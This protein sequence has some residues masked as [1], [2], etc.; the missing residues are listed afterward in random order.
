MFIDVTLEYFRM[1]V[2]RTFTFTAGLNTIRG[3]NEGGKSTI[4]HAILYAL[5]GAKALPLPV[6]DMVTWGEKS[7]KLKVTFRIMKA[8]R[9]FSFVRSEKGAEVRVDG[10]TLVTGQKEVTAYAAQLLGADMGMALKL[11]FASQK[12][13]SNA[14]DGGAASMSAY[15]EELS[16]MSLFDELLDAAGDY[17]TTG[18]TSTLDVGIEDLERKVVVAVPEP[19]LTL[20]KG[21]VTQKEQG[22]AILELHYKDAEQ[23]HM[24]AIQANARQEAL[25]REAAAAHK[26]ANDADKVYSDA[27]RAESDALVNTL[28]TVDEDRA[29][30]I[31]SLLAQ[32]DMHAKVVKIY[33]EFKKL[34]PRTEDEWDESLESMMEELRRCKSDRDRLNKEISE[35]NYDI[36]E[37]KSRLITETACGL[38]GK[39]LSDVPEVQRKNREIGDNIQKLSDLLP[40]LVA[41]RDSVVNTIAALEDIAAVNAAY[42]TFYTKYS[43]FVE[44]DD[45]VIPIHLDWRGN[46][47]EAVQDDGKLRDELA[48]IDA[49]RKKRDDA[50]ARLPILKEATARAE[51]AFSEAEAKAQELQSKLP[52]GED[53]RD[54][55]VD[56]R[57]RL[58]NL[59]NQ[60]AIARD[61]LTSAKVRVMHA[62]DSYR[63]AVAENEANKAMLE[64]L[65]E[66]RRVQVYNNN[67]VKKI[68]SARPIVAAKLWSV[69]L[70]SV[71]NMF[72]SMRGEQSIVTRDADTFLVN[73][74]SFKGVSGS[75]QDILGLAMRV[76]LVRTFIPD[77]TTLILDEPMAA[78]DDGRSASLLAFVQSCG[79]DQVILVTHEDI[80]DSMSANLITV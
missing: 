9:I 63:R 14:L 42:E 26:S 58:T 5:Y 47:P 15:I 27:V 50:N 51:K 53:V 55:L 74:K 71:S 62:E 57:S 45:S 61:E 18:P 32:Q 29:S 49:E 2:Q 11:M 69:V 30:T 28:I 33:D 60:L 73:G 6:D 19:D 3:K 75:A 52:K 10:G 35:T 37:W 24:N 77:T 46:P 38:C 20:Q 31:K 67:L 66:D 13:L 12:G 1:H 23:I 44:R 48:A 8:G 4:L 70:A 17:L 56:A 76:A 34:V 21:A 59:T 65:K 64:R 79:F 41:T 22:V 54:E 40:T 78:C 80:S 43:E 72:S 68:R 7:N 16:G 36:R 39:D 25:E